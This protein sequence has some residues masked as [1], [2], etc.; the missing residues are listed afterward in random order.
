MDAE[1]LIVFSG[2][3]I[4]EEISITSLEGMLKFWEDTRLRI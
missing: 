3:L 4:R 1:V 2:C